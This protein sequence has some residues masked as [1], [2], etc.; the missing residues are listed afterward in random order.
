[1]KEKGFIAAIGLMS[2]IALPLSFKFLDN[3]AFA[4]DSQTAVLT[5]GVP[6]ESEAEETA[7]SENLSAQG[8]T[9]SST[10]EV[11][12]NKQL[13]WHM[14]LNTVDYYDQASGRF[15]YS[16]SDLND[17]YEVSFNTDLNSSEAYSSISKVEIN[18]ISEALTSADIDETIAA[19]KTNT[20]ESSLFSDG[21]NYYNIDGMARSYTIDKD[22][23]IKREYS[24]AE[25]DEERYSV[26]D[27][28]VPCYG[29]RSDCTNA[30]FAKSCIF[31][32]EIAFGYLT[33]FDLWEIKGEETYLNRDCYVVSG[34]TSDEYGQKI[35]VNDFEFYVDK[36][37]GTLLKYNGYDAD[38]QL[39]DFLTATEISFD[40]INEISTPDL[41]EFVQK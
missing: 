32:Q 18:N 16:I 3:M 14:M 21:E 5:D 19:E 9:E 11:T 4:D 10:S 33:D 25:P 15:F 40:N 20:Y 12:D 26:N 7:L 28:G 36:S 34:T 31:P 30:Y 35:G 17:I 1:M 41:V 6:V 13:I 38:G 2:V 37:T 27:E 22:A 8:S 23:A 39:C 29:Y 24:V